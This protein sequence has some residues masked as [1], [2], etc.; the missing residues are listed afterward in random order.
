[1]FIPFSAYNPAER[2]V[3]FMARTR[4]WRAPVA[5]VAVTAGAGFSSGR[6]V[7]LF[8]SQMGWASWAGVLFAS[9]LFGALCGLIAHFARQTGVHSFSGVYLRALEPRQGMVVGAMH[10]LLMAMTAGVM[11]VACGELAMLALPFHNAFWMGVLF[12]LAGALLLNLRGMRA[13]PAAGA[14]A[15]LLMAAFFLALAA[16]PRDVTVHLNYEV[17]PELFGSTAAAI[18]MGTLHAALNASIAGGVIACFSGETGQPA[19]FGAR[20]GALMLAVLSAANAA[21]ARGGEKLLAQALPM[22]VL[23]ARWG[24][25]GYYACIAVMALGS[26]ATLSAA[27]GALIGQLDDGPRSRKAVLAVL[28]AGGALAALLGF[29]RAVELGYPM[30]GWASVFS[31]AALACCVDRI[32]HRFPTDVLN[33]Q[34]PPFRS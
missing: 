28:A 14:A 33:S 13:L 7:A 25:F 23:A 8:F 34:N 32:S 20:C 5:A 11:L 22:V 26:I 2:G 4:V 24:T 21:M 6:E 15:L 1:M 19:A 29:E 3:F 16:D 30:L 18:L 10:G 9:A 27:V 17:D 12:A 31:L